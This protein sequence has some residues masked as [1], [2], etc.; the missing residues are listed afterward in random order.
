MLRR[1]VYNLM[2]AWGFPSGADGKESACQCRR[3]DLGSVSGQEG[4]LEEEMA[5]H[6]SVLACEIPWTEEPNWLQSMG[7]MGSQR[8]THDRVT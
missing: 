4:P 1:Y 2:N 3:R 7:S 6:S 5:T 8:V